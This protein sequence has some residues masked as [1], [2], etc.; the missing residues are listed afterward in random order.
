[1]K[2][3]RLIKTPLDEE[4]KILYSAS[5]LKKKLE[6]RLQYF[7]KLTTFKELLSEF[8]KRHDFNEKVEILKSTN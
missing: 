8:T 2:G 3:K 7:Y 6:L 4:T 5:E 1:M